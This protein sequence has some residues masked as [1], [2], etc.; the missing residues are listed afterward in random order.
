MK[1]KKRIF[2]IAVAVMLAVISS[3]TR[4][5]TGITPLNSG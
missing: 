4:I 3:A 2:V 1:N 5:A